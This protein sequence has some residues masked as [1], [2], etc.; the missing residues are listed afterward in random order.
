MSAV[1]SSLVGLSV[2]C[3]ESQTPTNRSIIDP[4][5]NHPKNKIDKTSNIINDSHNRALFMGGTQKRDDLLFTVGG[6]VLQ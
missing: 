6:S 4:I 2:E 1:H 3:F 5:Q